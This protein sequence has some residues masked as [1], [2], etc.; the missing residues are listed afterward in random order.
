[1]F[2]GLRL[3]VSSVGGG[4]VIMTSLMLLYPTLSAL[5][6]VGTDLVQAVPLVIAAAI[7]HVRVTGVGWSLRLPLLIGGAGGTY[8]GSRV[9][10]RVPSGLIR[11]GI[12]I[13]LAVTAAAM[14]GPP[15]AL[16]GALAR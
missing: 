12:T 15:P 2:G 3:G 11:R 16:V 5:R 4:T 13:V 14:L 1:M 7:G 8:L 9:A 10:G 6:L